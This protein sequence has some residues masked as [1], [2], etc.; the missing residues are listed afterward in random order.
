VDVV[1]R[2][3]VHPMGSVAVLGRDG[4]AAERLRRSE[5]SRSARGVRLNAASA[6]L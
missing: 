4:Y 5:A 1:Q 2:E 6:A 3:D